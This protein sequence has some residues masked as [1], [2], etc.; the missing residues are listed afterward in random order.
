MEVLVKNIEK[1]NNIVGIKINNVMI[2]QSIF[3]DDLSPMV[4]SV[5][6]IKE[7]FKEYK[8]FSLFSSIY[9]NNNKTEILPLGLVK[10][11]I[12]P[13]VFNIDDSVVRI[14]MLKLIKIGG[15]W[16][17]H[18]KSEIKIKNITNRIEK[19]KLILNKWKFANFSLE[20]N[21]LIAKTFGLSQFIHLMQSIH[22]S[23]ED[24]KKIE[25][26]LYNFIWRGIDKIKRS[27]LKCDYEQGGLKAPN[28]LYLNISL[29]LKNFL[30]YPLHILITQL[31]I[32]SCYPRFSRMKT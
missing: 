8:L 14:E 13:A 21:I 15:I 22:I 6:S 26:I 25:S 7:V 5:T 19:T 10:N 27:T 20:G 11:R 4:D 24:L 29:K 12:E 9:L 3:S 31:K 2:K 17:R 16:F 28:P 1:N 18:D 32:Y 23:V 30:G